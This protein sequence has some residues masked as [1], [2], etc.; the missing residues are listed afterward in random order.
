MNDQPQDHEIALRYGA[1]GPEQT[2]GAPADADALKASGTLTTTKG[3]GRKDV[4]PA[5]AALFASLLTI[6]L[7]VGAEKYFPFDWKPSDIVK[8]Y[9]SL[10]Q[11]EVT[12]AV[13]RSEAKF[14]V[15]LDAYRQQNEYNY[16]LEQKRFDA[17]VQFLAE[18][19]KGQWEIVRIQAEM[20]A[21]M[22]QYLQHVTVQLKQAV[23]SGDVGIVNLS[24]MWGR[25]LNLAAPG[26]G[27]S[28]LSYSERLERELMAELRDTA[29]VDMKALRGLPS[30]PTPDEYI[31]KLNEL[32]P[33]PPLPLPVWAEDD[34]IPEEDG[35][36]HEKR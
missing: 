6:F 21:R 32:R 13:K 31:A 23:Q 1:D 28:A 17:N 11:E 8:T 30:M 14:T 4:S 20:L 36:I 27:D 2:K 5:I 33:K 25:V 34:A 19:Y 3:N 16:Q 15:R 7:F 18:T 12:K 24:R 9:E 22:Q 10:V 26:M 29:K 35:A